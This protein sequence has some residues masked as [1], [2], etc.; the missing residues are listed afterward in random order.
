MTQL[1]AQ[2]YDISANGFY[3]ETVEEFTTKAKTNRNDYGQEVEEYEL[4]FIDGEAVDCDL[5]KAWGINQANFGQYLEAVDDWDDH[6]KKMFII[7]VGQCGYS[8]DPDTIN[9]DDFDVDIYAVE[10]M[11]KLAGQLI[12]EGLFG[13]I[14]EHLANYIDM[15][16]IAYDPGY[17]YTETEI[18]GETLIYRAG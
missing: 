3:F 15:D 2:P 7:A 13:K 16:A 8:F 14:P 4:Q 11:K 10:S 12:D 6:Q 17:D 5:A 9:P 1:H 18:A